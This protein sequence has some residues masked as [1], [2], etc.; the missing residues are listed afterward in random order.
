M[1]EIIAAF[2]LKNAALIVPIIF[3]LNQKNP[4]G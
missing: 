4:E 2:K 1:A 3:Y